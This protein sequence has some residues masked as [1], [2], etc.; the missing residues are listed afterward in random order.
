MNLTRQRVAAA[1]LAIAATAATAIGCGTP[2]TEPPPPP[3]PP[4]VYCVPVTWMEDPNDPAADMVILW[5]YRI[6][7]QPLYVSNPMPLF[8][9][10]A[11]ACGLSPLP[12]IPGVQD[13]GLSFGGAYDPC[14]GLPDN[15]QGY[16]PFAPPTLPTTIPQIDSF[17]DIFYSAAAIPNS[18]ASATAFSFSGPGTIPPGV[19][20]DVYR[21]IRIPRGMN[22]RNLCPPGALSAIG[23]FLVDNGQVFSEPGAQ[24]QP[25]VPLPLFIQNPGASAFYKVCWAPFCQRIPCRPA[26]TPCPGDANG[27]HLVNFADITSV[28]ANFNMPCP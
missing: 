8:P 9:T 4:I 2:P 11:C 6:D 21:K 5:Y 28:L 12:A 23:L 18:G 7:G 10:Q 24:G 20:W 22:P 26:P 16:G 25:P 19:V 15:V 17:F 27:D 14:A 1:A 13:L 3:N